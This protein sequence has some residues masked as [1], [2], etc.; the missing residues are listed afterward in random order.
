MPGV[1][2]RLLRTSHRSLRAAV[3]PTMGLKPIDGMPP[4]HPSVQV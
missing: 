1:V 2:G 3:P 4:N